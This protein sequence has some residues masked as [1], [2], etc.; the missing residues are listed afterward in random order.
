L[1]NGDGFDFGGSGAAVDRAGMPEV[2]TPHGEA[3]V[4]QA[5]YDGAACSL[6]CSFEADCGCIRPIALE[7]L[8]ERP[9]ASHL[10]RLRVSGCRNGEG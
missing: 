10:E 4:Q 8:I 9:A 6:D 7:H 5:S 1:A 2:E 3:G